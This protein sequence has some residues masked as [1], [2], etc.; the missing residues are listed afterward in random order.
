MVKRKKSKRKFFEIG[1]DISIAVWLTDKD[2]IDFASSL[3]TPGFAH[4]V[5]VHN[6]G[7]KAVQFYT[8]GKK[9]I[10]IRAGGL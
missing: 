7:V 10:E 2:R 1:K 5:V 6:Y 4:L 3:M 9:C 8:N